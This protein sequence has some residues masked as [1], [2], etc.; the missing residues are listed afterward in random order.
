MKMRTFSREIIS[1]IIRFSRKIF[2]K[3]GM[4][5]RARKALSSR[6]RRSACIGGGRNS[7]AR[8]EK[9]GVDGSLGA[10]CPGMGLDAAALA[11]CDDGDRL[12]RLVLHVHASRRVAAQTEGHA[13]RRLRRLLAGAWRRL[14]RNEQI[15]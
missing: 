14:L 4:G 9:R 1:A 13:A 6:D 2:L 12:D 5:K 10:L 3:V 7:S 15:C 8:R 11:A